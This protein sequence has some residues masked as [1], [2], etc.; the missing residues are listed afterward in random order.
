MAE[1]IMENPAWKEEIELKLTYFD[2]LHITASLGLFLRDPW[3]TGH[4]SAS[5]RARELGTIFVEKILSRLGD[6]APPFVLR[7]WTELG[8]IASDK[9]KKCTQKPE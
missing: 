7:E 1:N 5:D 4:S 8:F 9:V 6:L 2:L 3:N